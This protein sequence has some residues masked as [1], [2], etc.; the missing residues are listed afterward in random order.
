MS[1]VDSLLLSAL[2]ISMLLFAACVHSV[3]DSQHWPSIATRLFGD[4]FAR[5]SD[6]IE[7]WSSL[8]VLG[9]AVVGSILAGLEWLAERRAQRTSQIA[10]TG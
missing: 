7:L 6:L 1:A 8:A 4:Q 3:D 9:L 2:Y 5:T 10:Q